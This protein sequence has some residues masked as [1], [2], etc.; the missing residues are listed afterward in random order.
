MYNQPCHCI[1][2]GGNVELTSQRCWMYKR[3]WHVRAQLLSHV[4]LF[5]IP[6][7]V[8]H[9]VSLSTEFSKKESWSGLPF[10]T[11]GDLPDPGM[12][13]TSPG[14]PTLADRFFYH[15]AIWEAQK[16]WVRTEFLQE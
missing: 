3:E 13:P 1:E 15:C 11:P 10:P 7:A 5:V 16:K 8:A 6:W 14:S 4:Q 9:Q 2:F 12:D